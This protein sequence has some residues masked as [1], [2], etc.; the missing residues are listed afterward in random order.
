MPLYILLVLLTKIMPGLD[1]SL[2]YLLMA[3]IIGLPMSA[4]SQWLLYS[5]MGLQSL[6]HPTIGCLCIQLLDVNPIVGI[7]P[8]IGF[9]LRVIRL[10]ILLFFRE[11]ILI[12]AQCDDQDQQILKA[13]TNQDQYMSPRTT[14][15]GQKIAREKLLYHF[16]SM[17]KC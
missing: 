14:F 3:C 8:V 5:A 15:T 12:E 16:L 17:L 6:L 11:D 10:I 4:T 7:H 9:W 1:F 13:P 2:T